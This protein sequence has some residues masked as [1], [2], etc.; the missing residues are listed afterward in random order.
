[1]EEQRAKE[2][3]RAKEQK[4]KG[5]KVVEPDGQGEATR[6]QELYLHELAFVSSTMVVP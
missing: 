1:M 4:G 2:S 6:G 5:A 3:K